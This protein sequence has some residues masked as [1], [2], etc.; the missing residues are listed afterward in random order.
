MPKRLVGAANYHLYFWFH[1]AQ[2]VA[3]DGRLVFITSGEWL[4]SDYGAL[5]QRWLLDHCLVE[6]V[7]ESFAEA[8]F[9]E[10]RVGTVVL[11]AR[12]CA[13]ADARAA[14]AVT[15]VTLRSR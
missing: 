2:F 5:L 9:T 7:V 11:C 8:W 3:P 14:N 15:F 12:R 6:L 13:D 1:A 10:A 4:D